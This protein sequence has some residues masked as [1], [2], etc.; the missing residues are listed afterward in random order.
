MAPSGRKPN[1]A[2][3]RNDLGADTP[4]STYTLPSPVLQ[5]VEIRQQAQTVTVT[6]VPTSESDNGRSSG[7]T[8]DGGAI[9]GSVIGSIAGFVLIC[10]VLR[11]FFGIGSPISTLSGYDSSLPEK[12]YYR[13]RRRHRRSSSSRVASPRPVVV[14]GR[15]HRDRTRRPAVYV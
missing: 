10:W 14:R 13:T 4:T 5:Q 15:Q 7:T 2:H 3:W 12:D 6:A 1:Q 8:L 9:A 11:S